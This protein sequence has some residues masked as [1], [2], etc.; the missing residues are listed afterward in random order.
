MRCKVGA[1]VYAARIFLHDVE[2]AD[3]GTDELAARS[4]LPAFPTSSMGSSHPRLS[5]SRLTACNRCG[6]PNSKLCLVDALMP[7][8]AMANG[9]WTEPMALGKWQMSLSYPT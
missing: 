2:G 8:P 4:P 9:F 3:F 7:Y 5:V 6:N 1:V